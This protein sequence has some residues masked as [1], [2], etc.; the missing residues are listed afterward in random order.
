MHEN[1][2]LHPEILWFFI[3]QCLAILSHLRMLDIHVV[4]LQKASHINCGPLCYDRGYQNVIL[5]KYYKHTQ[6]N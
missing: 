4:L 2:L 6:S 3:T 1:H 5:S